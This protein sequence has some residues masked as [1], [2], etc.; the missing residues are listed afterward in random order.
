MPDPKS[1]CWV[2]GYVKRLDTG[3]ISAP[4]EDC[5][6]CEPG[7]WEA[8]QQAACRYSGQGQGVEVQHRASQGSTGPI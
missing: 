6:S 1:Y 4:E 8:G 2:A 5:Q 7:E 3:K